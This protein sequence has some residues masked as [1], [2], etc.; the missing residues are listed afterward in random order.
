MVRVRVR[1]RPR[2]AS[3]RL[4]LSAGVAL[5]TSAVSAEHVTVRSQACQSP[6]PAGPRTARRR[7]P[8]AFPRAQINT[9]YGMDGGYAEYV[10]AY[11]RHVV[12]VPDAMDSL[13][14]APRGINIKGSIVGTHR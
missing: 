3:F 5:L 12:K 1:P 11:E 2:R 4:Q 9:G 13:D 6:H 7:P 8:R 10:A 14:A